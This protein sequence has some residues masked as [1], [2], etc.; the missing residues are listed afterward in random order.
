MNNISIINIY[1][2]MANCTNDQEIILFIPH[3]MTKLAMFP[4]CTTLKQ[5]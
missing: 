1:L 2:E 3:N 5:K 4:L